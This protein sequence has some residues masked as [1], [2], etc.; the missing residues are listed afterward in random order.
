[1]G[2]DGTE[3]EQ[4]LDAGSFISAKWYQPAS[5]DAYSGLPRFQT[6]DK[7]TASANGLG[8]EAESWDTSLPCMGGTLTGASTLIAGAAITLATVCLF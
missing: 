3:I 6:G 8:A 7:V 5:A 4:G 2:E 1:M